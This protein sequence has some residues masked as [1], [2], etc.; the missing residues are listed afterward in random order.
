M[1]RECFSSSGD[2]GGVGEDTGQGAGVG[3]K[4]GKIIDHDSSTT[5]SKKWY[6]FVDVVD[7][8]RMR[9]HFGSLEEVAEEGGSARIERLEI[10]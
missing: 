7:M 4:D 8:R 5:A 6:E 3:G 2:S 1:L 9:R 10:H